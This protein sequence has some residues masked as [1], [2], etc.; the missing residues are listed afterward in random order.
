MAA[1]HKVEVSLNT[2]AVEVGIPS[3]QTVN[4]VVPVAGPQG[5]T[6]PTGATGP[7]GP[8]GIPGTGLEVLTTQ[9]DLLYQGASTGQRLPIGST[10]QVLKVSSSGLPAWG[11]E[12][13]PFTV[14]NEE[15]TGTLNDPLIVSISQSQLPAKVIL[16]HDTATTY[17]R[18]LLPSMAGEADTDFARSL[19]A[20]VIIRNVNMGGGDSALL[21]VEYGQGQAL[22][23]AAGYDEA[24]FNSDYVFVWNG[25]FWDLQ[26]STEDTAPRAIFRPKYGCTLAGYSGA[27]P[28]TPTST[29]T[30]GELRV[31]YADGAE[32]LYICVA[33]NTWRRITIA[34]W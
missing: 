21:R 3:P 1:Y 29:G 8:Q 26:I 32:R 2:N 24:A 33:N 10:G 6:G 15:T 14:L 22:Y 5:P 7:Q 25:A 17:T 34:A 20:T 12:S 11:A 30:P 27:K 13:K 28:A 23:P 16:T 19:D 4:V 31:G 18:V 9:G